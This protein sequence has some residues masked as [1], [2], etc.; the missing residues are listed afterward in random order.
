LTNSAGP[1][2]VQILVLASASLLSLIGRA[3]LPLPVFLQRSMA[4]M[5]N[6]LNLNEKGEKS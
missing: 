4:C 2:K 1:E 6:A 3:L 5:G